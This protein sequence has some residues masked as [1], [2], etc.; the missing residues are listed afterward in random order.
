[1]KNKFY[2]FDRIDKAVLIPALLLIVI[3][4]LP[5][6]GCGQDKDSSSK[7]YQSLKNLDDSKARQEYNAWKKKYKHLRGAP[8]NVGY[9]PIISWLPQGTAASFGPVVVSEDRRYIRMGINIGFSS[10]KSVSTFSYRK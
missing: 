9:R 10:I 1:M 7:I 3:L 8:A 5:V 2:L 4:T 6:K